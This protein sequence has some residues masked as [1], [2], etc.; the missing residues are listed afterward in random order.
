MM[1]TGALLED[2]D[3][4]YG[5][6][7]YRIYW[8]PSASRWVFIPTGID[9]TF[10]SNST[11]VFGGTGLL[12]Q[13][14]L[15][16]E[17]CTKEY[18]STVRDVADRFERLG[19]TARMDALLAVIDATSQADPKRPYDAERMK[20]ARERMRGFLT[21]R[22]NEVRAALSCVDTGRELAMGAC[23]GVVAV[24]PGVNQCLEV[25]SDD[26]PRNNGGVSVGKCDGATNQ[27]W[28]LVAKGDAFELASVSGGTCMDVKDA[29]EDEGAPV[30]SSSC[31]GSDSQLFSLRPIARDVQLVARH[32]GKCVAVAPG[33]PKHA[34]LVQVTCA[35]DAAQTWRVQRSIYP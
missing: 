8:N 17:R 21:R 1:A 27:R 34:A 25:V 10:V 2:W 32:S 29:R 30:Q 16:S 9:Q 3:N 35:Q 7:N 5:S 22:P 26:A 15:S 31:A 6:N 24:N 20:G 28:H 19:L 11:A 23:A 14:C 33:G 13:K 4:Y 12:F 18:A